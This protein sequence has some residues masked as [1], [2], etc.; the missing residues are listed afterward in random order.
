M[1]AQPAALKV[2]MKKPYEKPKL[3]VYGDLTQLT[4]K[5]MMGMMDNPMPGSGMT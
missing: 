2:T 3:T 5:T 1:V 4:L